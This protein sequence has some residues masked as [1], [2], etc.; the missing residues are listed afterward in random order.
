[1]SD[2]MHVSLRK[3]L[4]STQPAVRIGA[5]SEIVDR[6]SNRFNRAGMVA[7]AKRDATAQGRLAQWLDDT[8]AQVVKWDDE[9]LE[10]AREE[11]RKGATDSERELVVLRTVQTLAKAKGAA[12]LRVDTLFAQAIQHAAVEDREIIGKV[13]APTLS[14]FLQR[15]DIQEQLAAVR[16]VTFYHEPDRQHRIIYR[17]WLTMHAAIWQHVT[18]RYEGA[19]CR[20]CRL[21]ETDQGAVHFIA[22]QPSERVN[23]MA[24]DAS[25]RRIDLHARGGYLHRQCIPTWSEWVAI[26]SKYSSLAEAEEADR[27]AGRSSE[28][29]PALPEPEELAPAPEPQETPCQ[30]RDY[31]GSSPTPS[32]P[33]EARRSASEIYD[34]KLARRRA[35]R[36]G[37][38]N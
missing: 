11:P 21:L 7:V 16:V 2:Y 38:G 26:A 25:G 35:R 20:A 18:G 36:N 13:S 8:I 15:S 29:P 34:V 24:Q 37:D 12:L 31:Y 32:M 30:P 14:G 10:L 33:T 28:P 19:R 22:C 27:L 5:L 6:W 9:L 4:A 23:G 1:V 17:D 3:Q